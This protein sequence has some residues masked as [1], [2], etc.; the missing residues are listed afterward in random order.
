MIL[1][2]D[3][4]DSFTHNLAHLL[5]SSGREIAVRR[6]DALG[7]GDVAAMAPEGIV[8]SPGPGR[9]ETA[10]ITV[11]IVRRLGASVPIL[12]VCLGHQAIGYAYGAE[13]VRQAECAHGIASPVTHDGS[14]IFRGVS[15]PFDAGRYH[16]L[17]ISP[18]TLPS[19]LRVT[20][21]TA[22]GTIMGIAHE[23]HPV[24][25]L[26]FHPESI[27]TPDGALIVRNWITSIGAS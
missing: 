16:S 8:I 5:A 24:A 20:A 7:A 17:A 21:S 6:N 9:P 11:E 15:N 10:G 27:L 1:L 12:G 19:C 23:K 2:I 14:A 13:V 3:N 4:Y 25:G 22:D 26:Q 18:P